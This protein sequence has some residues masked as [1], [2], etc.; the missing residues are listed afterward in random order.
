MKFEHYLKRVEES[1]EF[2]KF[3]EEHAKSYLCAGFFVLDFEAGKHMHQIDFLVPKSKKIATFS[4]GDGV[5]MHL[6]D[7]VKTKIKLEKLEPE[8]KTDIDALKGIVEDEMHNRSITQE[9]KK[10]IA[11]LQN[12][13]GKKIWKLN[14]ITSDMGIIKVHLDDETSSI[15]EME[16]ASLFDF[17]KTI[18][19]TDLGSQTTPGK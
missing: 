19:K 1:P 13:E 18:P 7:K 15:L 17:I 6:S 14:C 8:T 3:K 5:K 16:K 12:Q 2:K 10:I 11:V 9:I 4:L